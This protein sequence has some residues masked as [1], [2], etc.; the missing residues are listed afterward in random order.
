MTEGPGKF[1]LFTEGDDL[2]GAMLER[3]AQSQTSIRLE[4][5]IFAG[6]EIGRRF[7]KSLIEAVARG[8]EVRVLIDAAG[9]LFWN[10]RRLEIILRRQGVSFRW[11]HRWSWRHPW[12]YNRRN[13][14]KLL[15]IDDRSAF[16]GGF[17]IHREN[18]RK[19]VGEGRWRDTHV[20]VS[21]PLAITSGQQFDAV[22]AGERTYVDP[23]PEDAHA[24]V[25]SNI[26][27]NCR[28][29]FH[30]LNAN[31]IDAAESSVFLTTAYF[32]PGRRVQSA[33]CAAARRGIDVRLLVPR[34][35]DIRVARWA[36]RATYA[37][38]LTAGVRIFEYLPRAL[39][40]KCG[41]VDGE[42]SVLGS[43]NMD[44][45]SFGMNYELA[46]MARDRSLARQLTQQ[47]QEDVAE[48]EQICSETW[49]RRT[50]IARGYEKLG[51]AIERWL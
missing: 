44:M 26:F 24:T 17:N 27:Q 10:T 7:T 37:A 40:A 13:H 42:W 50:W 22:W 5:Y 12:R 33:L 6:D 39:H 20:E 45:R 18:S 14:R 11:Y 41:V 35:C 46:L 51:S 3:I 28:R 16:L 23:S 19:T 48:S 30:C 38:L 47:F 15:V 29:R 34:K 43:A 2:Y 8:I 31:L 1:Q 21:G 4:S 36:A 49:T 25:I 9:S 32:V